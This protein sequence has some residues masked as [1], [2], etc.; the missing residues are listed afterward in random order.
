MADWTFL[1]SSFLPFYAQTKVC[2]EYHDTTLQKIVRW[3]CLQGK[4]KRKDEGIPGLYGI[5]ARCFF[6][7]D[8]VLLTMRPCSQNLQQWPPAGSLC[9]KCHQLHKPLPH[10]FE[11]HLL[12]A[13]H[14]LIQ[15]CLYIR[16]S[17]SPSYRPFTWST[18]IPACQIILPGF[19]AHS[20]SQSWVSTNPIPWKIIVCH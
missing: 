8:S 18:D 12:A 20:R 13:K 16:W 6:H 5:P 7:W 11:L 10:L 17:R 19:Q 15:S 3:W 2:L 14:N 4:F 9:Q 1:F